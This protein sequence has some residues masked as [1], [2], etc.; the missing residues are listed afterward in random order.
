MTYPAGFNPDQN[1]SFAGLGNWSF[2]HPKCKH[3]LW[4]AGF[5]LPGH[6]HKIFRSNSTDQ[7]DGRATAVDSLFCLQGHVGVSKRNDRAIRNYCKD[8]KL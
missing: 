7:P 3:G 2:N 8:G 6:F 4:T 1:L 5:Q